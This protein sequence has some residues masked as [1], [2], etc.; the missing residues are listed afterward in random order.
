[1]TTDLFTQLVRYLAADVD[2]R[3]WATLDCP[4]CGAVGT[5]KDPKC[6]FGPHKDGYM[7]KCFVC[8]EHGGL[9]DLAERVKLSDHTFYNAPVR[10]QEAPRRVYS[11]MA[12][13]EPIIRR[14]EAHER[15]FELWQAH[16]PV[17]VE[18]IRQARLGVGV[19]PASRCHHERLIVPIFDGTMCVGLRGRWMGCA[20]DAR[21]D[22]WLVAGGTVLE[23]LPLYNAGALRPGCVVWMVENCVDARLITQ[24][25][26][27]V[28]V[29][30]YSTSYW[31]D[32]WLEPLQAAHPE[33][34]VVALD[35][36]LV[37]NGGAAR[38]QEFIR[39]WFKEHPKAT[40]IPKCNGVERVNA[41]LAA[42]LPA[43]LYD[44]G[45]AEHKADI[46]SMLA[47]MA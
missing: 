2:H 12:D 43:M 23:N 9:K 35:Q 8:G 3:G 29:A 1:M 16:K 36:D 17:S 47:V 7:W 45:R 42:G 13:P 15:R 32:A 40:S 14:Y 24:N 37:G 34:I 19:L 25:T 46:G 39:L 22:K 6:G 28:G 21:K 41:L 26:P 10:L 5:V 38:R 27:F 30:V 31:R 18:T 44:W 11:W 4:E 33:V 20:C